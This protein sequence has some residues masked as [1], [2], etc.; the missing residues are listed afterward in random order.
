MRGPGRQAARAN[1]VSEYIVDQGRLMKQW[2]G[3]RNGVERGAPKYSVRHPTL[4][5][6]SNVPFS[7]DLPQ[8]GFQE[9]LSPHHC[10]PHLQRA[11]LRPGR[12]RQG[13]L[14]PPLCHSLSANVPIQKLSKRRG[15]LE[16]SSSSA[17]ES[18]GIGRSWLQGLLI[19][20]E[21][22]KSL[23]MR[24]ATHTGARLQTLWHRRLYR[25]QRRRDP[26]QPSDPINPE[27]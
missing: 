11:P 3:P 1:C 27:I 9:S 21:A 17:G 10:V 24:G 25:A 7:S 19:G 22:A 12:P 18:S 16:A 13:V 15:N 26:I 6:E 20:A 2:L 23:G 8:A 5:L 4:G 14:P